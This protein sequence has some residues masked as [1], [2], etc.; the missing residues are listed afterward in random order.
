MGVETG[1]ALV[2]SALISAGAG[3]AQANK[4]RQSGRKIAARQ[5]ALDKKTRT[6]E[7]RTAEQA[8]DASRVSA[9]LQEAKAKDLRNDALAT[10]G[11]SQFGDISESVL[12]DRAQG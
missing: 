6:A 2:A 12:T 3:A 8:R 7:T 11:I 10:R 5:E 1:V 9:R 4:A